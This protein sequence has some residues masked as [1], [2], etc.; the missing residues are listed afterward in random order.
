MNSILSTLEQTLVLEYAVLPA[1]G[2]SQGPYGKIRVG[3]T[4]E[5]L[6]WIW[7]G[8]SLQHTACVQYYPSTSTKD[9]ERCSVTS[10]L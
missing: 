8:A 7:L 4:T 1:G 3:S 5:H 10:Q 2:L 9:Q 6:G